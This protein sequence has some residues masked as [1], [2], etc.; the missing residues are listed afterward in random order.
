MSIRRSIDEYIRHLEESTS[1]ADCELIPAEERIDEQDFLFISY[2]HSDYKKVFADLAVLEQAGIHFWYDEGLVAGNNWDEEVRKKLSSPHCRG[3]IFFISENLFLSRS[4]NQEIDLVCGKGTPYEKPFF[5]VNL[6]QKLPVLILRSIMR[7]D[8]EVL[9]RA[10]L[11]M[12]RI[13]ALANAFGDRRTYLPFS[14]LN[15][16]Q[17]LENA[18]KKQFPSVIHRENGAA[19]AAKLHYLIC[20]MSGERIPLKDEVCLFGRDMQ[21][22]YRIKDSAVSRCHFSI[23]NLMDRSLLVDHK[24]LNGTY[25]NDM[26]VDPQNPIF[27]QNGDIIKAGRQNFTYHS[28]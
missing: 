21:L 19:T 23:V 17:Q 27:L 9:E 2:S 8:D 25:I 15:H 18:V 22:N 4:V 6:T 12:D 10:A 20:E 3:V 28:K 5:S 16:R 7:M 24:T 13:G 1:I 11:D 26:R 14:D